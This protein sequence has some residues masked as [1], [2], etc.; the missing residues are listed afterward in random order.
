MHV[1]GSKLPYGQRDFCIH[2]SIRVNP[3]SSRHT[4]AHTEHTPHAGV[5]N[6]LWLYPFSPEG[7]L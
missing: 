4:H 5:L 6:F 1:F 3:L 7:L 2:G